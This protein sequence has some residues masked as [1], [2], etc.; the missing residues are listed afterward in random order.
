MV[1]QPIRLDLKTAWQPVVPVH[2]AAVPLLRHV[3]AGERYAAQQDESASAGQQSVHFAD[4][5]RPW[6]VPFAWYW[7]MLCGAG[8]IPCYLHAPVWPGCYSLRAA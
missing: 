1:Y 4:D 5:S 7:Q 3:G 8:S 6:L 2:V